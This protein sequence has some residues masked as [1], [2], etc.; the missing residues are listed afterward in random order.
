MK[1]AA[2]LLTVA[3]AAAATTAS[4]QFANSTAGASKPASKFK[5]E[6]DTR[7]YSRLALSYDAVKIGRDDSK[8]K[9]N[10]VSVGYDY[11]INVTRNL[12]L[13][14]EVGANIL[15]A[16]GKQE[17]ADIA[18]MLGERVEERDEEY[19][20][21]EY[22]GCS[23]KSKFFA[24]NI[25]VALSYKV[26]F[27]KKISLVPFVGVNFRGMLLGKGKASFDGSDFDS[28]YYAYGDYYDDD[29]EE[30]GTS[31]KIDFFKEKN[32]GKE[33]VWKRFQ[34]GWRIGIGFN[35]SHLHVGVSYGKDFT[36]LSKNAKLSTTA[37]SVGYN[38]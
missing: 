25:P 26:S 19:Y 27:S 31:N 23:L 28:D 14:V 37:V 3:F 4:A 18:R 22:E 11:G 10:G 16:G 20:E 2:F 34:M 15:Y 7:N 32:M 5:L 13:F 38:F 36:E 29:Y 8:L 6:K 1:T 17:G 21:Y 24:L 12:P 35:Y 9:M 30:A 33:G